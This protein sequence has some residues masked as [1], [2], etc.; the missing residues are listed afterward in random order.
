[1]RTGLGRV[2]WLDVPAP[3][4]ASDEGALIR[5]L[6]V[7]R[8][9]ID[10]LQIHG[11]PFPEPFA[12][13]HECIGEVVEVGDAVKNISV[14]QRVIVPYQISCG[15]CH[16]C[17]LGYTASCGVEYG[18]SMFGMRPFSEREWGGFLSERGYVPYA[19]AMLIPL[20]DGLRPLDCAALADNA[21]MGYAAVAELLE[22]HPG[23]E[24][25]VI[26]DFSSVPLFAAQAALARGAS[27]VDLMSPNPAMLELGEALGIR[28]VETDFSTRQK[29]Y[30][31]VVEASKSL[32]VLKFALLSTDCGGTCV[33][34]GP[35]VGTKQD[36]LLPLGAMY[37]RGIQLQSGA[38]HTRTHLP[39]ALAL[40]ESGR[41]RPW[42]VTTRVVHWGDAEEAYPEPSIKLVVDCEMS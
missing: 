21:T 32:D 8:C 11:M 26:G 37:G 29:R 16:Y 4:L 19:D 5:P 24:V 10:L 34:T 14:G 6:V 20:P 42:D 41:F 35:L 3:T 9:D 33:N 23:V 22:T 38:M 31:I 12:L 2:E 17:G 36:A 13:G 40:V 1:M 30:P 27:Q 25:G 7:S 28:P 15:S 18:A 39:G